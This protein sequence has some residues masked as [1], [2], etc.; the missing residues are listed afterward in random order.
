MGVRRKKRDREAVQASG[1]ALPS[2]TTAGGRLS[3][4][5]ATDLQRIHE[6]ALHLL[7]EFGMS[8]RVRP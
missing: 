5:A 6:A 2:L 7:A 4:L 1:L 8:E 3:V